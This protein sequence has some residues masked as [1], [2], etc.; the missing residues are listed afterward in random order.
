MR[1]RY[2]DFGPTLAAEKLA[3]DLNYEMGLPGVGIAT[4]IED[5]SWPGPGIVYKSRFE[6][7]VQRN[8]F[9]FYGAMMSAPKNQF[10]ALR[11]EGEESDA[12]ADAQAQARRPDQHGEVSRAGAR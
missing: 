1:E 11:F 7:G 9:R 6:E 10:P 2:A 3:L 8:L 12:P 5:G 4:K